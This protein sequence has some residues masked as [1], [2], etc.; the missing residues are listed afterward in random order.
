MKL[1]FTTLGCPDWSFEKILTEAQ[2]MGFPAIEI[3]G[4]E[5]KMEADEI[6]YFKPGRQQETKR[7]LADHGLEMCAF[8]SSINFH[9]PEK[10]P[11]MI[12]TG[13]RAI[14]V[15][16]AMDIPYIRLFGDKIPEGRSVDEAARLAAEGIDEL[17]AYAEGTNV[18]I[19]LEVHGNFN[20]VEVMKSLIAQTKSPRFGILW[21]IEHSDKIYGDDFMSFYQTVKPLMKH[22][23]VKDHLRM[24]D[25]TFKLCHV[26]DGDIP[27]HE[28]VKAVNADG[29]DGYFSLEWEKK[30]YPDL[31][32]CE[33]EFP[34]YRQFMEG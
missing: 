23:H 27:I 16:Q 20:T 9:D 30:W 28:I 7:R 6:E 1:S 17:C 29:F 21:D 14:D 34:F 3:R 2:R 32:D 22:I 24:P 5:G 15:C 13:R 31:P 11:Q 33:T 25:G 10:K 18:G 12:E 19:L 4:I 8:G 26:G